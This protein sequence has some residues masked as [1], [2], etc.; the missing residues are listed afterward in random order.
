[1]IAMY[2]EISML[3]L[4]SFDWKESRGWYPGVETFRRLILFYFINSITWFIY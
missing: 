1:M 3:D 4:Y 2:T